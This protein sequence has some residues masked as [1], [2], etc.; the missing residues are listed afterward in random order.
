MSD[1]YLLSCS[2][3]L[4]TE[5]LDDVG[6]IGG[7]PKVT[8]QQRIAANF[9]VPIDEER[10]TSGSPAIIPVTM[11]CCYPLQLVPPPSQPLQIIAAFSNALASWT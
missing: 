10:G 11:L 9:H 2:V 5:S 4:L 7:R 1:E 8:I 6:N 3:S